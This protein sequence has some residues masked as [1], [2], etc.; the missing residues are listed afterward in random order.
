MDDARPRSRRSIAIL[1]VPQVILFGGMLVM[2]VVHPNAVRSGLMS[3]RAVA[4]NAVLFIGWL[5]LSFVILPRV[6]RNAIARSAVLTLLAIGAVLVLVVPT[7]RDKKVIEAFPMP[8]AVAEE[9]PTT[10]PEGSAETTATT[11]APADEPVKVSTGCAGSIT[12]RAVPRRSTA[13]RTVRTWWRSKASTS[14]RVPTTAS[15]SSAA[16][17]ARVRATAPSSRG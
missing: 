13:S 5:L 10:S 3:T 16:T 17:T 15:T 1:A 9:V 2:L 11:T 14:N 4:V 12:T 6:L 7:L 8:E